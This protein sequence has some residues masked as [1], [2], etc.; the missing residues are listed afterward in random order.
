LPPLFFFGEKPFLSETE[1]QFVSTTGELA[2]LSVAER[3]PLSPQ[4]LI[5]DCPD[6]ARMRFTTLAV[7]VFGIVALV[8][9]ISFLVMIKHFPT[10]KPKETGSPIVFLS[11]PSF[12]HEKKKKKTEHRPKIF[13]FLF[14]SPCDGSYFQMENR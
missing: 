13:C 6:S 5:F 1:G 9:V 8:N 10:S 4:R 14:C 12:G 11:P 7:T 2:Y 3:Y